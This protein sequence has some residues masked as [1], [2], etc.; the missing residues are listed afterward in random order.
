MQF[1][2]ARHTNNLHLLEIF[3]TSILGFEVLG[4]FTN[5]DGYDGVF[6]G[7]SELN[8]HLEFT[9]S[10]EKVTHAFDEDDLL[11][12]YPEFSSEYSTILQKIENERIKFIE[13]K[14]LYW[15]NNGKMI[16]DP[17]GFR[18]VISNLKAK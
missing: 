15:K 11:V 13:P 5:H 12:F 14:N 6:I 8:W 17:D 10:T 7:K 4:N 16:V 18:I 9:Q 2:Y 3:Y 1:R